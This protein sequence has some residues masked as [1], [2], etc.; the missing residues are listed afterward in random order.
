MSGLISALFGN[1]AAKNAAGLAANQAG[2]S[3]SAA[4]MQLANMAQ[5]QSKQDMQTSAQNQPGI[6]RALLAFSRRTGGGSSTLG[7]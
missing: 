1:S 4:G 6:G 3:A 5:Q 2:Q 7:G